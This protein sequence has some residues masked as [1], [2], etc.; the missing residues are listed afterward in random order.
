MNNGLIKVWHGPQHPGV[1]GNMSVELDLMGETIHR[2]RTHVGYLHRG[3]EKLVE[4]RTIM[5]AFTIVCRICVPESDPNEENFA[6]GVEELAGLEVP[7]KA[8]WIRTMVLEMSRLASQCLWMAGQSGSMGLYIGPQWA[9]ADR[10]HLL[11]L[12]DWLTG[13]RVYH[14]YIVPGGVRKDIPEG[15]LERLSDFLDYFEKRLPEYDKIIF[16][17]AVFR[18]RTEGVG[19]VKP[20][21]AIQYGVVGP[22]LRGSG[23][24]S[25][26]R[27]DE[28]YL[29]Y[30]RVE[31][32]V[33]TQKE[34]D[35]YARAL[36]RRAEMEQSI[37]ILRQVIAQ[38]PKE[39]ETSVKLKKHRIFKIPRGET[40]VR[41]ESARGE[42][43][44]YMA[45]DGTEKLRRMQ[46]K[47]PSIVHGVTLLESILQGAQIAD[48]AMIMNS[49]GTCPPEIER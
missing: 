44:Y 30:D 18:K 25:D 21:Q 3:F 9:V 8:K 39:G 49:L 38:M 10:D 43:A 35:V 37:R 27:K 12:F 40:F 48:V 7:E 32:D 24:A 31:F 4:R 45:S 16:N 34:G 28:P 41:T 46:V 47:G 1:T 36:V 29:C 5:Q 26:V 6:R 23:F 15:F 2:A 33:P 11:D 42:F 17:N 13:G 22:V 19:I 20:E 14:M